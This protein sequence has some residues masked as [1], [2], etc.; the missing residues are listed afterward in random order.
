MATLQKVVAWSMV[1]E[2]L[3]GCIIR[4]NQFLLFLVDFVSV[5]KFF[6]CLKL[7]RLGFGLRKIITLNCLEDLLIDRQLESRFRFKQ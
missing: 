6:V 3:V 5:V 4:V 1:F 7:N 2:Y